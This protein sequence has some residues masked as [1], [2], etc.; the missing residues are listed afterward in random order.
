MNTT[1]KTVTSVAVAASLITGGVVLYETM[2]N[3]NFTK[4]SIEPSVEQSIEP[5]VAID[6][7]VYELNI[8]TIDL[9]KLDIPT[10][11][12]PNLA[13]INLNLPTVTVEDAGI[14]SVDNQ[15]IEL[16]KFQ[17]ADLYKIESA[18]IDMSKLNLSVEDVASSIPKIENPDADLAQWME[19]EKNAKNMF[20]DKRS[21]YHDRTFLKS[22]KIIQKW[23]KIYQEYKNVPVV[24]YIP[25]KQ[26]FRMITEVRVPKDSKQLEILNKNL[27]YYKSQGYDSV[28]FVFDKND[29]ITQC[30]NTILY[31]KKYFGM[32]VWFAYTGKEALTETVF[33]DSDKYTQMLQTLAVY[34]DGYIN[35]WRR[36]SAHL[37][38]QDDS[39]KNYT[40]TVIRSCSPNM[41]I[42]GELYFGNTHKYDQVDKVGF[43]LNIFKNMS[44]V[45]VVNFGYRNVD[46]N[47]LTDVVLKPYVGDIPKIACVVGDKAYYLTTNKNN[48]TYQENMKIKHKVEQ[49]FFKKG[50]IGVVTLSNDGRQM[51]TNNLSS[52][53]YDTLGK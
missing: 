8:P 18:Q 41:P 40:N 39:F 34:C 29:D 5:S 21:V 52:T 35:S 16:S 19:F 33:M 14:P 37:W 51:E 1:Q 13:E 44:G 26:N 12:L 9:P 11:D 49:R 2:D 6:W 27:K 46:V 23:M 48:L 36:T 47:Y 50:Y 7:S 53:P 31:I 10:I 28:L 30:V 15:S 43:G 20:V 4:T 38:Q 42:I 17:V 25:I 32:K 45:M 22:N 3:E 24:K